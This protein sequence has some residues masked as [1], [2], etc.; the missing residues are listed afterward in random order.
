MKNNKIFKI[1][2]ITT[3][4]FFTV[5]ITKDII[6]GQNYK[7][8]DERTE[9]IAQSGRKGKK[10][11]PITCETCTIDAS[12]EGTKMYSQ[13][14]TLLGTLYTSKVNSVV[15]HPNVCEY[16]LTSGSCLATTIATSIEF[17]GDFW[18]PVNG[19]TGTAPTPE[20]GP[21]TG[22]GTGTGTGP[23]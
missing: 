18:V 19:G 3:L 10:G 9:G 5:F 17:C 11:A 20:P 21:G 2:A 4:V 14:G 15:T 16:A 12:K 8:C 23:Q 13:N 7:R 1:V 6:A 22:T